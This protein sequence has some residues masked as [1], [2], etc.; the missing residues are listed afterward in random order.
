MS[1]SHGRRRPLMIGLVAYTATSI[2]C[3]L[4]PSVGAAGLA[5]A[6]LVH[7]LVSCGC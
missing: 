1:D 5:S 3:A 4:A 7:R 6:R 2:L